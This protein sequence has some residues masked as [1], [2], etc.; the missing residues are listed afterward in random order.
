MMR[1]RIKL[2]L[3]P[4]VCVAFFMPPA[5]AQDARDY[6]SRPIRLILPVPPGGST[7]IVARI[8]AAGMQESAGLRMVVD[9]RGGASGLIAGET[10]ARA[11]PDGHTLL[12][13]YA[14]FTTSPFLHKVPYDT[15]R[16]FTPITQLSVNPLLVAVN[17]A[18]PVGSVQELIA[19]AKSRPKGLN[20]SVASA[21][22]A[23]HLALGL[24]I[25]RS[26]VGE[27]IVPVIYKGG[28]PAIIALMSGEAQV[29]VASLPTS[30]PF[31][32]TGKL[33]VLAA[34]GG[35]RLADIPDV[36]SLAEAGIPGIDVALPWQAILG[37]AN[38][39]R[40]VVMRLYQ[41][42]LKVLK[43]PDIVERLAAN[44]ALVV[45][46]TPEEFAAKIR[47]DLQVFG[48]LIPAL[49]IKGAS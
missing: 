40:P 1:W 27:G 48:K 49:G 5:G 14:A 15:V 41:E 28:G 32:K 11:A 42:S 43:R 44:G 9:N 29:M 6:G 20:A 18:L 33:K 21:G 19:H 10:V 35:K 2:G 34:V 25:Q 8:Y 46:S 47:H 37:P 16:D 45:G 30:L 12:F 39:P 7:D 13:T 23:G 38:L 4:G 26:G 17:A 31:M 22:S 3:V 24:F 36:P